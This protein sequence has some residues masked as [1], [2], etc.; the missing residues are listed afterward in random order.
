MTKQEKIDYILK[1]L[2][3]LGFLDV[4]EG[5]DQK[6]KNLTEEK[7][8]TLTESLYK[9]VKLLIDNLNKKKRKI[10]KIGEKI[11]NIKNE[12]EMEKLDNLLIETK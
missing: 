6:I 4:N 12:I 9:Q 5:L 2:D 10:Q 8:T 1:T 7:L 3:M 11:E